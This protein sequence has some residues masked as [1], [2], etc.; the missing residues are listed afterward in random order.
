MS[1]NDNLFEAQRIIRENTP[2]FEEVLAEKLEMLRNVDLAK[3]AK[4]QDG[5][6]FLMN[7]MTD[8][9]RKNV[10]KEIE[11]VADSYSELLEMVADVLEDPNKRSKI[12]DE[13]KRRMG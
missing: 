1:N 10:N 13:L 5:M 2:N 9:E 6:E 7:E 8:E 11:Q 12:L 3:Q 4:E